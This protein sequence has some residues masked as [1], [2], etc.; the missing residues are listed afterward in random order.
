MII[1]ISDTYDSI[2]SNRPYKEKLS[3]DKA[4]EI[5]KEMSGTQ[6]NP[7]VVDAFLQIPADVFDKLNNLDAD[8]DDLL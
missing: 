8:P 7:A 3:H 6:F 4:L 1:A 5:I 2:I